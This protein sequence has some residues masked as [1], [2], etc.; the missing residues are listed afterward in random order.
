LPPDLHSFARKDMAELFPTLVWAFDLHPADAE[1]CN[2]VLLRQ[3]EA[4][5]PRQPHRDNLSLQSPHDLHQRPCFAPLKPK[6]DLAVREVM[7]FLQL[8]EAAFQVTGAWLNLSSPGIR[9]HAHT[10][11][12][13]WLSMV[14]YVRTPT[15]GDTIRFYDPRPQ[16]LVMMPRTRQLGPHT[17]SSMIL[18]AQAGRLMVFP[19]WLQ[20]SV[21]PNAGE[22]DRVSLAINV[23]FTQFGERMAAPMW[24]PKLV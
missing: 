20:H 22:G 14:Y 1:R 11:P 13:N 6:V 21:D 8:E 10:H 3:L 9:H 24:K 18:A 17:G 15:G 19:S 5:T 4:L 16:A 7:G 2:G 23:M 12:N